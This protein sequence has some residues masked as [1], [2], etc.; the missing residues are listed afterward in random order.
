MRLTFLGAAGMV[1]GS[2]YLLEAGGLHP[3]QVQQQVVQV[4][5]STAACFR[6][7]KRS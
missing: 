3:L 4:A 6:A 2:S 7:R 1:T 5:S